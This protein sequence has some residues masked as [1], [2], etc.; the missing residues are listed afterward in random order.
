LAPRGPLMV[1]ARASS[2][3]GIA[4][5][6]VLVAVTL[7]GERPPLKNLMSASE[8][9]GHEPAAFPWRLKSTECRPFAPL[10]DEGPAPK[11]WRDQWLLCD[12]DDG[13]SGPQSATVTLVSADAGALPATT[14]SAIWTDSPTA[15]PAPS[16]NEAPA[17]R[18]VGS[19]RCVFVGKPWGATVVAAVDATGSLLAAP[20]VLLWNPSL[21]PDLR[22]GDILRLALL[23]LVVFLVNVLSNVRLHAGTGLILTAAMTGVL[24]GV[25]AVSRPIAWGG[26]DL[27]DCVSSWAADPFAFGVV[28]ST[29]GVALRQRYER[30]RSGF[31]WL[32]MVLAVSLCAWLA[33]GSPW[34]ARHWQRGVIAMA[35]VVSWSSGG[36]TSPG[37]AALVGMAFSFGAVALEMF[38]RPPMPFPGISGAF[39]PWDLASASVPWVLVTPLISRVAAAREEP[40]RWT[41]DVRAALGRS[42]AS[43][44]ELGRV[45]S[46]LDKV[47][48]RASLGRLPLPNVATE[49]YLNAV[50]ALMADGQP[51][52]AKPSKEQVGDEPRAYLAHVTR[53]CAVPLLTTFAAG[54]SAS[55]GE[56]RVRFEAR[57][58]PTRGMPGFQVFEGARAA[59]VDLSMSA[60]VVIEGVD[61]RLGVRRRAHDQVTIELDHGGQRLV[62]RSFELPLALAWFELRTA[63]PRRIVGLH[64]V[65]RLDADRNT[66]LSV[67]GLGA[68]LAALRNGDLLLVPAGK[69]AEVDASVKAGAALAVL[70]VSGGAIA[71]WRCR[72]LARRHARAGRRVVLL[73]DDLG[74][75]LRFSF[76]SDGR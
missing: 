18:C 11:P 38:A 43:R 55:R 2:R 23:A 64:A 73:V 71:M 53:G 7:W 69:R 16:S 54:V 15:P 33:T 74:T 56:I 39:K 14:I 46:V 25:L 24:V 28:K 63:L 3:W 42:V 60:R 10:L 57:A 65:G 4:L 40:A 50:I 51:G 35:V 8:W 49:G 48:R 29:F 26:V 68:K 76:A 47:L 9:S 30:W 20:V 58:V 17:N 67:D 45:V 34:D 5:S 12:P 44:P 27:S 66:L 32:G 52:S 41:K 1:T 61:T 72:W 59:P 37:R 70:E 19:D 13:A 36:S 31:L 6:A 21:A 75:A 62:G 22:A